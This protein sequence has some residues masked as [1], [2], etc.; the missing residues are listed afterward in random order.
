MKLASLCLVIATTHAFAA[1]QTEIAAKAANDG[2]ALMKAGKYA[3]A[4]DKFRDAFSRVPEPQYTFDLCA[5]EYQLGE[6]ANALAACNAVYPFHPADA[7]RAKTDQLVAKI[8][9]DAAAQ[10]ISL[11][12]ASTTDPHQ[13]GVALMYAGKYAEAVPKFKAAIARDY[14][15]LCAAEY[16]LGQFRDALDACKV[17]GKLGSSAD[18]QNK[19]DQ[20]MKKIRADAKAQKITVE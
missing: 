19:T 13:E 15:A 5:A 6:F 20:V 2:I 8:K 17:V 16:Q 7:L 9:G 1:P 18:L 3:E 14:F 11:E 12:P 4:R 10:H